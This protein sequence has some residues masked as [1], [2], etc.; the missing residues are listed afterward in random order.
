MGYL[1]EE[2]TRIRSQYSIEFEERE[3]EIAKLKAM[4]STLLGTSTNN[5][6]L[7]NI[8]DY[9][10]QKRKESLLNLFGIR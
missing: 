6:K 3:E 10:N 9:H 8:N 4:R 5:S 2:K 1:E 7:V